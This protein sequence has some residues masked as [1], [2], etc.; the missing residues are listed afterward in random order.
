MDFSQVN[1]EEIKNSP[2]FFWTLTILSIYIVYR[3]L[4]APNKAVKVKC[5]QFNNKSVK[6][7]A[8]R[9]RTFPSPYPNGWYNIA[10]VKDIKRGEIKS[11]SCL[12]VDLVIFRGKDDKIGVL[13]AHCP[14][15]GAHMGVGGKVVGNAI[16]CPFHG[17][18]FNKE[19]ECVHIPYTNKD[20]P[21]VARTNAWIFREK[22]GL[23]WLWFDAEKNPP[24]YELEDIPE[25]EK[26]SYYYCDVLQL[27]FNQ[28]ISEMFGLLFFIFVI[29]YY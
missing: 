6:F 21:C 27:E 3:I 22:F 1:L 8:M 5:T 17:W 16:E 2:Y 14:H 19:G 28:H 9:R 26:K 24:R 13:D 10:I 29:N 18:Q 4:F 12:G 25:I 7:E 20:I 23:V 11:V 15:I